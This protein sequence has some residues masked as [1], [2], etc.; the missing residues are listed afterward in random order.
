[1]TL[2][3]TQVVPAERVETKRTFTTFDNAELFYRA[4]LP[5]RPTHKALILV[6]RGHEHSGR[7]AQF[8]E[9]LGLSDLAVF[10]YD[11]RGH[12]RSPGDRGYAN[13]FGDH[14]HDLEYFVRHVSAHYDV[15]T[16]NIVALGH[17]VGA[18]TVAT[19][20]HD[21]APQVR[22]MILA[23]PALRVK[24]YVP[25]AR[26]GLRALQS[27]KSRSFIKSYVKPSM[28]THDPEQARKY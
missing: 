11:A 2:E 23:T 8:V 7:W 27:V 24:L 1:T 25:F 14:V 15:P 9:L 13:S 21:Y 12:G 28:L 18:V 22:G 19:W 3:F 16:E 6:H 4:W 26:A 10:A 5:T 20:V 17:S